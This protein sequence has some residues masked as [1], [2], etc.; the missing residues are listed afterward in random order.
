MIKY[1]SKTPYLIAETAYNHKGDIKYLLEMIDDIAEIKANAIKI[2]LLLNI[3][4]YMKKTHPLYQTI[5][6]WI[7]TENQWND[8][9]S[10]TA[11]KTYHD[12]KPRNDTIY[13]V[14]L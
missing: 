8:V 14:S 1:S 3:D 2:H 9:L 7:F 6:Q 11:K 12:Y 13:D 10:Y 5:K 4:S